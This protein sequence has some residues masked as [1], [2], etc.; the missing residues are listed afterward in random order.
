MTC[1]VQYINSRCLDR[2]RLVE[3]LHEIVKSKQLAL[4]L[5]NNLAVIY[6]NILYLHYNRIM[7]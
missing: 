6:I 3:K 5:L 2:P 4:I 1:I 7:G